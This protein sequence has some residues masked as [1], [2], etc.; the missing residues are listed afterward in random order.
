MVLACDL[1]MAIQTETHIKYLWVFSNGH[2]GH[3]AMTI[4]AVLSCRNVRPVIKLNKVRHL[5]N[6]NPNDGLIFRYRFN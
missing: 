2:L 1:L 3:I 4:L 6:R 5:R